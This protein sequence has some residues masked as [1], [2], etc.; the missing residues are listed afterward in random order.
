[1][2]IGADFSGSTSYDNWFSTQAVVR[3]NLINLL[4]IAEFRLRADSN[5][6]SLLWHCLNELLGLGAEK[7]G[8]RVLHKNL[9]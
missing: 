8:L 1:M 2:L 3:P 6:F 9:L 4:F 5:M 7:Y